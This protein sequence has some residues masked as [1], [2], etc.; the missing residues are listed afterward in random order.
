MSLALFIAYQST[1]DVATR[2]LLVKMN[3]NLA[4]K[5][6][7]RAKEI[8][9]EEYCDLEQEAFIGVIKAVER[10]DPSKGC[11]FSSFAVPYIY[12]KILQYLRDKGHLIRLSQSIQT[13]ESKG[14][15]VI[16]ELTNELGRK[17]SLQEISDKLQ[18]SVEDYVLAASATRNSRHMGVIDVDSEDW[19]VGESTKVDDTPELR[20][21]DLDGLKEDE[22]AALKGKGKHSRRQVWEDLGKQY[23][24]LQER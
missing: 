11:A 12:G 5:V 24:A 6:A 3:L 14:R 15:Q 4:R 22:I 7:H 13:L 9:S 10:F 20:K 1:Q 8:C 23:A 21:L 17:P 19:L 2:N 18:C 16:V